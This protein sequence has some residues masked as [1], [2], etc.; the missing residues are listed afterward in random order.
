LRDYLY[1]PLGGSRHGT[2][3]TYRNLM[4]TMLLGGLWHGAAWTF[5]IWGGLHGLYLIADRILGAYRK[6]RQALE[7]PPVWDWRRVL[8]VL[9]TFHLVLLA[10]VFFRAPGVGAAFDY[11]YN[12]FS[13][14]GMGTWTEVLPVVLIP[15][16]LALAIDIPQYVTGEHVFLLRLPKVVRN[17]AWAGMLFLI[18]LGVGTRAPFIYFQF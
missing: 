11:L 14:R 6:A 7:S 12:L 5:V 1:I 4:I 18:L 17:V 2:F 15:W 16:L 10:W 3:K 8:A 13:F 9:V